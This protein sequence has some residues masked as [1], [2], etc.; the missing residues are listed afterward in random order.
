MKSALIIFVRNPV[1]SKVK[2]RLA[3]T[4]GDEKALLVYQYLLQYTQSITKDL[5]VTKFVYYADFINEND[6]WNGYEKKIQHGN[7]IGDRM[8]NAFAAL[9][10]EGYRKVCIIGSDCYELSAA[11]ITDAFENLKTTDVVI[12]PV[13]DGGYYLLG[14]AKL[15]TDFFINKNWSTSTVYSSTLKDAEN[16]QLTVSRLPLLNDIDEEKDLIQSSIAY[17]LDK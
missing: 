2:T 14:T 15:V 7:D 5:P 4:T 6:L 9:F 10:T 17:L 16:L 3:A 11:I 12:G 8:K 1:L 13:N